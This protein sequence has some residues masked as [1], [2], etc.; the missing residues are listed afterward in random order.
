MSPADELQVQLTTRTAELASA[1]CNPVGY[2]AGMTAKPISDAD[3]ARAE[4]IRDAREKAGLN[5]SELARAMRPAVSPQTVQQWERG[6]GIR[7]KY[8]AQVAKVLHVTP[9]YLVFGIAGGDAEH[10]RGNDV[11]HARVV[12]LDGV[13]VATA[14]AAIEWRLALVGM[15]YDLA[16][17]PD[18]FAS[19]LTWALDQSAENLAALQSALEAEIRR[20]ERGKRVSTDRPPA[21]QADDHSAGAKPARGKKR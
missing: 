13:T 20:Q 1:T 14:L 18:V 17:A 9:E 5:Q 19:A 7:G 10:S 2:F 16:A 4:R 11:R 21:T 3:L 8:Q 6:G 12:R 15:K